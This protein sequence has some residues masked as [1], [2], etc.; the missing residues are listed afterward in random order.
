MKMFIKGRRKTAFAELTISPKGKDS[1]QN[2]GGLKK[3]LLFPEID[4]YI[5]I[6]ECAYDFKLLL[7]GGGNAARK[8]LLISIFYK[9]CL[10]LGLI[11]PS[12][13][14]FKL[15]DNRNKE[16]KK[17]GLKKARKAPQYSKR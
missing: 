16:R 3:S 5:K 12:V 1:T 13:Y 4:K 9:A 14:D 6:L 17:F 8:Q 2:P 11:K 7:N 15:Y 10:Y